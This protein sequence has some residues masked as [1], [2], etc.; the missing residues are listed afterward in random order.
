[1]SFDPCNRSLNLGVH[2]DSN[3]QSGSL[4]GSVRVHSFTV[5]YTPGNMRFDSWTSLLACT[6]TSPC[7]DRKPKVRVMTFIH[8]SG[9]KSH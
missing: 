4:L 7:L 3:S 6:L 9:L 1:M 2:W 5:S 8:V